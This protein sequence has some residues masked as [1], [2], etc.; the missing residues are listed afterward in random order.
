MS[1]A[2]TRSPRIQ[3]T[4]SGE[5]QQHDEAP[6]LGERE[7]P[8]RSLRMI[9]DAIGPDRRQ[10]PPRLADR[11]PGIEVGTEVRGDRR[12][13]ERGRDS[14]MTGA[15]ARVRATVVASSASNAHGH[16]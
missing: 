3:A 16:E 5:Q 14:P 4:S 13:V 6:E 10:P 15:A 8:E 9:A 1:T 2:S 7:T 12:E 11:E